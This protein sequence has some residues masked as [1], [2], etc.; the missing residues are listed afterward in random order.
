MA[1][2]EREREAQIMVYIG[3]GG[4]FAGRIL[5]SLFSKSWADRQHPVFLC[6]AVLLLDVAVSAVLF[7]SSLPVQ[8]SVVTCTCSEE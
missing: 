3:N 2:N 5:Q 1:V 8:D 7:E 6:C 4:L